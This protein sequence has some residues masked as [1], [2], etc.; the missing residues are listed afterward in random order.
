MPL[1]ERIASAIVS[2]RDYTAN[3]IYSSVTLISQTTSLVHQT[4][5][6]AKIALT[7]LHKTQDITQLMVSC[8]HLTPQA[9]QRCANT[10]KF[11]KMLDSVIQ[12]EDSIKLDTRCRELVAPEQQI[13]E[14]LA[15]L[16]L[17]DT[18]QHKDMLRALLNSTLR[19]IASVSHIHGSHITQNTDDKEFKIAYTLIENTMFRTKLLMPLTDRD[20]RQYIGLH[21]QLQLLHTLQQRIDELQGQ[22]LKLCMLQRPQK[23][24]GAQTATRIKITLEN[25]HTTEAQK[26]NSSLK[27][28][29]VVTREVNISKTITEYLTNFSNLVR[30]SPVVSIHSNLEDMNTLCM[31]QDVM[32]DYDMLLITQAFAALAARRELYYSMQY[33]FNDMREARIDALIHYARSNNTIQTEDNTSPI[34]FVN[35]LLHMHMA[36]AVRTY[37]MHN[38]LEEFV[39]NILSPNRTL[40]SKVESTQLR[41]NARVAIMALHTHIMDSL[42][43]T[44][45]IQLTEYVYAAALIYIVNERHTTDDTEKTKQLFNAMRIELKENIAHYAVDYIFTTCAPVQIAES[46]QKL[47]SLSDIEKTAITDMM[48]KINPLHL[49]YSHCVQL[50]Q[51]LTTQAIQ[52]FDYLPDAHMYKVQTRVRQQLLNACHSQLDTNAM[53]AVYPERAELIL[54]GNVDTFRIHY[55]HDSMIYT[56]QLIANNLKQTNSCL[57]TMLQNATVALIRQHGHKFNMALMGAAVFSGMYKV[58]ALH[59]L[60]DILIHEIHCQCINNVLYSYRHALAAGAVLLLI[61]DTRYLDYPLHCL[62]HIMNTVTNVIF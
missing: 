17:L 22:R 19:S 37:Y 62:Q 60:T 45:T 43:S 53:H 18:R 47:Y 50:V 61:G 41:V 3:V 26:S 29:S 11:T 51:Y 25:L 39:Y 23:N 54:V 28:F 59:M 13:Y 12:Y 5:R 8:S 4:H 34:Q 9:I 14:Y 56:A 57:P 40:L 42:A 55:A 21:E 44:I 35:Q 36:L 7:Q 2:V 16:Q 10:R 1:F 58:Q 27:T 15:A 38:I 6:G 46:M 24:D 33:L 49:N 32:M 52:I 48:H 20:M 30:L 31:Q